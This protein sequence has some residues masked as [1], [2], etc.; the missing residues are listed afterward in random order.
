[1]RFAILTRLETGREGTFGQL[2]TDSG[3]TATT[4][5]LPWKNNE[6]GHSCIPTG[7]YRCSWGMSSKFGSCYHL[8]EVPD[9]SDILIHS[10]NFC[11]D[12]EKGFKSDV[13]GCILIGETV[14]QLEKQKAVLNSK[15]AIGGL[16]IAFG[17][18]PFDLTIRW[19]E[20]K[21]P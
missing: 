10:G 19:A 11:G 16:R 5:E 18:D 8:K 6:K 17:L 21:E 12:K 2:I 14:G 1:M 15:H 4:G 7:L 20:G 13:E 3:F 9:R